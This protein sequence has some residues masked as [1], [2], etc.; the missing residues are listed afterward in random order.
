MNEAFYIK[1]IIIL[2]IITA[3][4]IILSS[5]II[6]LIS[7]FFSKNYN[8]KLPFKNFYFPFCTITSILIVFP[9]LYKKE[10]YQWFFYLAGFLSFFLIYFLF[11]L[12]RNLTKR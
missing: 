11:Y 2:K 6:V 7:S 10:Q 12:E 9:S 1:L 8:L 5:F 4:F 3:F